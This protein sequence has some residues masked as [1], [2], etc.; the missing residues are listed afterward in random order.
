MK[1]AWALTAA[2]CLL[3]CGDEVLRAFEPTA[4]GS[5]GSQTF[6]PTPLFIDDFED[7]DTRAEAPLGWWYPVN[8]RT[9]AQGFAI[10]PRGSGDGNVYALRSYGTGFTEWGAAVGVNLVSDAGPVRLRAEDQLCFAGRVEPGAAT[11]V[12]VHFLDGADRHYIR[13]QPLTETWARYCS[14][15]VDF[16]RTD[17]PFLPSEVIALQFFFPARASFVLWLDD[18]E[19][20]P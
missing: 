16:A 3:G 10:E 11:S 12:A 4:A 6:L 18:V 15:L 9:S 7:G 14:P 8:D 2:A 17:E 20:P 19:I 1:R 5:G 13:E